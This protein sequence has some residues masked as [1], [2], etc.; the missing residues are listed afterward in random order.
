MI[1]DIALAQMRLVHSHSRNEKGR[2]GIEENFT[3]VQN[4]RILSQGHGVKGEMLSS[5]SNSWVNLLI[6]DLTATEGNVMHT[7]TAMHRSLYVLHG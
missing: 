5:S 6:Q 7:P 3:T 2:K 1:A 4:T